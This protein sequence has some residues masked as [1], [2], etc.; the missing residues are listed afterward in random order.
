MSRV[1]CG[2]SALSSAT[3][4]SDFYIYPNR[5]SWQTQTDAGPAPTREKPRGAH[6]SAAQS[7]ALTCR[8]SP[9]Y[10]SRMS[11]RAPIALVVM[12]VSAVAI[13]IPAAHQAPAQGGRGRGSVDLPDG[14]GKSQVIAYCTGC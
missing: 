4:A 13:S 5:A 9:A 3:N 11:L 8:R 2:R 10:Y 7:R 6:Q 1:P 12:L 14:P